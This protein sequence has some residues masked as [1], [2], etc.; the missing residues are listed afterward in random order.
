MKNVETRSLAETQIRLSRDLI[1]E[2]HFREPVRTI[3]GVDLAFMD[4]RAV[5][6]CTTLDYHSMKVKEAKTVL[7][8]L[9]FPY[10]PEFLWFR[11]GPA[12][13]QVVKILDAEPDIYLINA[14]GIAHPRRLGCASHLGI[15]IGRPTIGVA[16]SEL[17]GD[18]DRLPRKFGECEPL[19]ANTDVIGWV[20]K[21]AEGKPLYVS[22]GHMVSVESAAEITINCLRDHRFPEPL[23]HSHRLANARKNELKQTCL[24]GIR[25]KSS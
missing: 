1:L 22:P 21:S 9:D 8:E 15:E 10:V 13:L 12:I 24:N 23:H 25:P 11:E 20:I 4:D 16:G 7:T 6:A 5:V 18:Y 19:K 14:H 2:D 17:Y 3:A